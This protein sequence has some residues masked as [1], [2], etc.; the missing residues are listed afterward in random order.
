[1][2]CKTAP[3]KFSPNLP[4]FVDSSNIVAFLKKMFPL[5]EFRLLEEKI[6]K[7][8][9]GPSFWIFWHFPITLVSFNDCSLNGKAENILKFVGNLYIFFYWLGSSIFD[10]LFGTNSE[11]CLHWKGNFKCPFF[12]ILN[13][14]FEASRLQIESDGEFSLFFAKLLP[15]S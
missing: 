14:I 6:Q 12:Y 9:F 2:I 3:W 15:R 4:N 8:F 5:R 11:F 1:M 13:Q 10:R 7:I